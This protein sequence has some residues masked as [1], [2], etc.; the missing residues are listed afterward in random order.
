MQHFWLAL[1]TLLIALL[2]WK[3]R[4]P[5]NFPPGP[6]ALPIIGNFLQVNLHNPVPDFNKLAKTYG[7]IYSIFLGGTPVVILHGFQTVKEVFGNSGLL[8]ADRPPVPVL[9]SCTK[10][11]G[12]ITAPY[13]REWKEQRRFTLMMFKNFGLGKRSM[14][15]RIYEESTYL[16]KSFKVKD[17]CTL[18]PNLLVYQA[19]SNIISS[20]LFGDRFDYDNALFAEL[21]GHIKEINRVLAGVWAELY[22][23]VPFTRKLPLPFRSL[24]RS[25]EGLRSYAAKVIEEHRRTRTP[26][27]T[28]DFI[29]GYLE[30]ME[31]NSENGSFFNEDNLV[32]IILDLFVA[33]TDTTAITLRWALLLMMAYPKVQARCYEEIKSVFQTKGKLQYEDRSSMPYTQAVIHEVQRFGNIAPVAVP[34]SPLKDTH[35]FGYTIPKGTRILPDMTSVLYDELEWKHPNE[36]YPPHFLNKDGAFVK[37]EAFLPFSIGPRSCIGEGLTRMELFIFFTE[38]LRH[39]EFFW[40]DKTT[41]PD[42]TPVF[43]ETQSPRHFIV[44]ITHRSD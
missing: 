18:D 15:C 8:F 9:Q 35:L 7:N 20:I 14:E 19:V 16:V 40:P 34:H 21:I 43:A 2:F 17:G 13:G 33:G 30:K 4:R 22:N 36:F 24:L 29:D 3:W 5:P 37:P 42:L 25:A 44:G 23:T 11:K 12:M 28:R 1:V 32:A 38:L 39:F 26:G 41:S 27:D 6:W 31:K 10:M